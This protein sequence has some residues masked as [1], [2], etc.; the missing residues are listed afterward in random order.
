MTFTQ[1]C[2]CCSDTR[3]R[4]CHQGLW[5]MTCYSR[6][7]PNCELHNQPITWLQ[8]W[9]GE[10]PHALC[11]QKPRGTPHSQYWNYVIDC[12]MQFA[13]RTRKPATAVCTTVHELVWILSVPVCKREEILQLVQYNGTWN[14]KIF[15]NISSCAFCQ[16]ECTLPNG[17]SVWAVV[18]CIMNLA[19][20]A[21]RYSGNHV[22]LS[23][24]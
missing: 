2:C 20:Y 16:G 15:N 21:Y 14:G 6:S 23:Q 1:T 13:I 7:S 19:T 5:L 10:F 22:L 17:P 11:C 3:E 24:Y 18:S 4:S 12:I 8:Y 9:N